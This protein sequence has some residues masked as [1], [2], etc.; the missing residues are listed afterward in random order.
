M[1]VVGFKEKEVGMLTQEQVEFY[2]ENGYLGIEGVLA[3]GE[4]EE[5]QR[6]TDEFVEKSR[7]I[8]E[9][10][11]VYD[12][13]PGHSKDN[14]QLRRLKNPVDQ[15]PAYEKALKNDRILDIIAQLIGPGIRTN[16][17]KL[18]MK[19]ADFGS[20]V[21]WHQDWAFYPYTNDDLL[22]VGVAIDDMTTEN[23]C[24]MVIP[25][26]HKGRIYNH[27]QNGIFVGAVTDQD[28]D[29]DDAVPIQVKAGGISIH[30]VR[31]LHGSYPNVSSKS[32]RLFLLMYCAADAWPLGNVPQ[33]EVFNRNLLRGEPNCEVRVEKVPVRIPKPEGERSGSIY[34]LQIQ[35]EGTTFKRASTVTIDEK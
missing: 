11:D 23:G 18:N 24:L 12:L 27:H 34:E 28:F 29:D 17:A 21:E 22:A 9:N 6:V 31:T 8:S 10:D 33:W 32:R 13:E 4:V 1:R 15:H 5:L 35:L 16:G 30:H 25:G 20:K 2:H 7:E 3:K 26:S 14:P 19:S